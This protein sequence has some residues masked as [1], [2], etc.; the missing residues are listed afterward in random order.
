MIRIGHLIDWYLDVT[1]LDNGNTLSKCIKAILA[2][3]SCA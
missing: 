2:I 1:M 3:N